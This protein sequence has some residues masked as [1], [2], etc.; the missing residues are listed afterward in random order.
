MDRYRNFV[1]LERSESEFQI[2]L[3]DRSSEVTIIA[4]HGGNIEPNTSEIATLIA[5]HD[6]NLFCFN[7]LKNSNNRDLHITS[8][9]FDH[10][11]AVKLASGAKVVIA[12]HGCVV[13]KPVVYLGGRD[14]ELIEQ[15]GLQLALCHVANERDLPRFRG[16]H[17]K[18][19][20]NRGIDNRGVQLE[21]SR[22]L[23]DSTVAHQAISSAVRSAITASKRKRE[24][25]GSYLSHEG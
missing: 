20:C 3:V 14:T 6:H 24:R 18:N 15:I 12:I 16:V 10:R 19:I 8:H 17:P 5:A 9:R 25:Q 13:Q 21:I 23:R 2:D 4:P 22:G 11:Q 1:E 7:G